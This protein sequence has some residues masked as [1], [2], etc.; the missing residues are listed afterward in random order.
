MNKSSIVVLG[1]S[2]LFWACHTYTELPKMEEQR[3][4][5]TQKIPPSSQLTGGDPQKGLEYILSGKYVGGGI[6]RGLLGKRGEKLI[7]KLGRANELAPDIPYSMSTFTTDDGIK[8][9]SGNCFS[10][11]AAPIEGE[12]FYGIGRYA[13]D[14]RFN[15]MV[16]SKVMSKV[17]QW[18]YGKESEKNIAFQDFNRYLAAISPAIETDQIGPNPAAR[19][20]EACM[21]HR[22][23]DDL[24]Y[25]AEKQYISDNYNIGCDVP[26]LW[27]VKKKNALYYTAVGKGDFTKLLMQA[28]VLGIKDSTEAR[29]I[30]ENFVDV[31]AWLRSLEPP[32]YPYEID[33]NL[34]AKGQAIFD[35][36]CSSCHGKYGKEERYPNKV[37]SI[38]V[39]KTDS[40]YAAYS[41]TSEITNWYNKSWFSQT[42]PYSRL[43]SHYG[44]IAPPLDGI[45]ATAPYLHNGSVPTIDALLNSKTRPTY[46]KRDLKDNYEFDEEKVGWQ[47]KEKN[48]PA[49][50]MTYDTTLPGYG[51][52]GH[53]FGDRLSKLERKAVL[54]YL[55]T[56]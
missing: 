6:P 26:P 24:T 43:E 21:Q 53:Y 18:S 25:R 51:N 1:F 36:K 5:K 56:L 23:A 11:H 2:L 14:F 39:V 4:W 8:V 52:M 46:W 45:W 47:Y 22:D 44:Y 9:V 19:L 10:C 13:S 41:M 54:E 28:A 15:F 16:F 38:D 49:G 7:K 30:Q 50:K 33:E 27:H 12:V 17:V 20:A 55:K 31:L 48:G 37:V 29:E 40:L 32:A 3:A 42:K 34:A 35:K